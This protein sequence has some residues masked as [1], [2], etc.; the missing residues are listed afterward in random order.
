MI[1]VNGAGS[2][3]L[4]SETSAT[5]N[6]PITAAPGKLKAMAGTGKVTLAWN[7]PIGSTTSYSVYR[8]TTPGGE[9]TTPLAS[10]VTAKSYVDTTVTH[11]TTYY[12][13]V[14][15]T[16]GGGTSPASNEASAKP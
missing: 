2:S 16:N 9:G 12:Y 5:P 7:A 11:G 6:P 13:V 1:A 14:T 3:P 4:S 10:G 8:A 15:A